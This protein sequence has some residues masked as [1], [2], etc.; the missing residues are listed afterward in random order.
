MPWHCE[1]CRKIR[2]EQR[3]AKA[4]EVAAIVVSQPPVNVNT[5]AEAP[6]AAAASAPSGLLAFIMN[7]TT[8]STTCRLLALIMRKSVLHSGSRL[9]PATL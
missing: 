4:A 7:P 5:S 2:R 6:A 9:F 1:P 8:T 3:K